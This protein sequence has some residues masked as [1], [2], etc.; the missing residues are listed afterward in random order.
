MRVFITSDANEESGVGEI[1]GRISGPTEDHFLRR[2]FGEGLSEVVIVLMCRDPD[3][4]FRRRV[5]LAAKEQTL[6]MDIM[7]PLSKM[8]DSTPAHRLRYV[9]QQIVNEVPQVMRKYKFPAFDVDRFVSTLSEWVSNFHH[10]PAQAR[11]PAK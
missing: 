9:G 7:L 11:K 8:R 6:Y 2:R 5:R 3:L 4:N 1:V 10:L